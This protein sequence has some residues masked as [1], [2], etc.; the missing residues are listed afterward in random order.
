[1]STQTQFTAEQWAKLKYRSQTD[2]Y[3][4]AKEVLQKPLVI[5]AHNLMCEFYVQKN[6]AMRFMEFAKSYQGAHTRMQLVPRCTY[7]SNIKVIDSV[8]WI[9]NYPEIRIM[10]VT[11]E[12]DLA[13]AFIDYLTSY[14]TIKGKAERNPQTNRVEGGRPTDFQL[15]FPEH[16]ITES[17]ARKGEY[18]TPARLSLPANLI[19]KDPTAGTI[20]MSG[21]SSGWHC[22]IL[23][24]DDPVSDKNSES[25][26]Q[27]EKLRDRMDM[28]GELVVS[29]GFRHTVATRYNPLDPYG[30]QAEAS[31]IPELYGDFERDGLK[32]MCR[33]CLWLK[34]QPYKQPD[35]KMNGFPAEDEIELFIPDWAPHK[36][37]KNKFKNRKIFF[38][39][40]LNDPV[41]AA[42]MPFTEDMIR[43]CICDHTAL[44]KQGT[45]F[46]A[47]DLA[48]STKNARD[49]SVGIVG[50]I[51]DRRE[52]WIT[53]I[54]R[55]RYDFSEKCFQ[56]VNTLRNHRPQRSAIEDA[57][58]AQSSMTE[59]LW[60]LAKGLN[61]ELA[62]DWI[63]VGRGSDDA[64]YLRMCTL[65]PWV[66]DRR[67][68]F[69]NTIECIDDLIREFKNIGN[70]RSHNDIPDA[71]ARLVAQ[72]SGTAIL[73]MS[74]DQARQQWQELRE[75]EMERLIFR[76]GK[77]A[78]G[79]P[80]D[81]GLWNAD[82]PRPE[83]RV[84]V[85]LFL[86]PMTGL[87]SPYPL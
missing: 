48:W 52:W 74:A 87:P 83:E 26:N 86:D 78:P 36:V 18:I 24:Y 68:H 4:L 30:V 50:M 10:T 34:G 66:K 70:K 17:E 69:L 65:H 75:S 60:R 31:G 12:V 82:A 79:G 20:S 21:T 9:I 22:D 35:Y 39:Q 46:T 15:L 67:I 5:G 40:Q 81:Q 77:Y 42:E 37:L 41:E 55:G 54:V 63:T 73:T 14:F 28:I 3:F 16:C 23:D 44:P 62:I 13:T 19:E 8:Q 85:D 51:D 80:W 38:S 76:R 49:Y 29:Y 43:A 61:V 71:M 59:T 25:G 56:I 1:M 72:Y 57:A 47:W 6:P 11:A 53:N 58:G 27:L 32:Y 33:P 84:E 2:L 64:K 7:K 45:T